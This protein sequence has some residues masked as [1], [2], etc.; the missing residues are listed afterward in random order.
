[1]HKLESQV[2]TPEIWFSFSTACGT[3]ELTH[4]SSGEMS[5]Q[6]SGIS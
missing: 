4:T 5:V 1:M 6:V 2:V 3:Q